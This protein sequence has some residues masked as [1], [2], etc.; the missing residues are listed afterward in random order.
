MVSTE[1][2][3]DGKKTQ[4]DRIALPFQE[5]EIINQPRVKQFTLK[6]LP[7][8]YP[9]DWKNMLIW[10]D[11]KWII[12]SLLPNFAGKVNLIYIDPPFATGADF[13]MPIKIGD[14]E[15]IKEPSVIEEIAYRDTWGKGLASYLQMMYDRL[16]LMR[17]LLA[18]NG[19]IY[20]H[21]DYRVVHYIKVILDEIFGKDNLVNEISWVYTG[22]EAPAKNKLTRKHDTILFYSK[23]ENYIF[24]QQ[25]D[26]YDE[27]YVKLYFIQRDKGGR[28]FQWQP[29]GK[30]SHYKQYLDES[31]GI[32][33]RDWWQI[34]PVHGIDYMK[35]G[36]SEYLGF[37]TQ[38]PE[39]L[40][41][42][43]IK[44]STNEGGIVADFFCG[45]GTT[46]AVAEKLGRRWI[47]ADLSKFAIHTTRKR[48]LNIPTCRPFVIFNLGNYQKH[49]F[50]ENGKYP[51]IERYVKFILELYR[52]KPISGYYFLH[53][54]K[55]W[56]FVHVGSVDSPVTESEVVDALEECTN[57][58]SGKGLDILGW[59]FEMGLDEVVQRLKEH[60]GVEIRLKEIPKEALEIKEASEEIKF[61]DRNSVEVSVSVKNRVTE[62]ELK[63]FV[64]ANMEYVPDEVRSKIKKFTDYID[65]WSVDFDYKNDVFHNQWQ[66]FRTRSNPKLETK[67][68][69]TYKQSGKYNILVKVIDIFGND[70]NKL[71]EVVVK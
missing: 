55:D 37:P 31:K 15:M 51:P 38:K 34:K 14:S 3:W 68:K 57:A 39:T 71:I 49:K 5:V 20:V 36:E 11:N 46:L 1:L 12:S 10:G 65:Y 50:M 43:I 48:L 45:S 25:Y 66:S 32:P 59:E 9:Q 53:G 29:D 54:R 35:R 41:E 13:S 61:F 19:A 70:S 22:R 67:C 33:F 28:L 23:S 60:S 44:I 2:K 17:E 52:A 16:V 47:G 58:A 18:D 4:V 21:L 40:L 30:G 69:H 8:G 27:K 7:S 6:S 64:L 62:L 42:R 24:N 63:N 56:R 26:P